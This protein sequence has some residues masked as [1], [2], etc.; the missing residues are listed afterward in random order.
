MAKTI[1]LTRYPLLKVLVPLAALVFLV[2]LVLFFQSADRDPQPLLWYALAAAVIAFAGLLWK[3]K[4]EVTLVLP[5]DR[6]H[7]AS[8]QDLQGILETLETQREKGELTPE[9]YTKARN[10]VLKEMKAAK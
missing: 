6:L 7:D 10:R 8:R 9:R 5:S 3:R 1:S 4:E 2:G